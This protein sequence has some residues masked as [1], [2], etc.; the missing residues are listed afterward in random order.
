MR[1]DVELQK[2]SRKILVLTTMYHT[3][4]LNSLKNVQFGISISQ[5]HISGTTSGH[6][7][8]NKFEDLCCAKLVNYILEEKKNV[9]TAAAAAKEAIARG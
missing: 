7:S 2:K 1:W 8:H 6:G 9:L 5:H 4:I 3:T